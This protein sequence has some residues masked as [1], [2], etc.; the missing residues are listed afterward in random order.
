KKTEMFCDYMS[1]INRE[2][3]EQEVY[4]KHRHEVNAIIRAKL[5]LRFRRLVL[6]ECG[7]IRFNGHYNHPSTDMIRQQEDIFMADGE[8]VSKTATNCLLT[9]LLRERYLAARLQLAVYM[10][11]MRGVR[12]MLTLKLF[13]ARD[14]GYYRWSAERVERNVLWDSVDQFNKCQ[15]NKAKGTY[16]VPKHVI[17]M[18]H[19]QLGTLYKAQETS[20]TTKYG[21]PPQTKEEKDKCLMSIDKAQRGSLERVSDILKD[22]SMIIA[23]IPEKLKEPNQ[24]RT[25]DVQVLILRVETTSH[26]ERYLKREEPTIAE[27]FGESQEVAQPEGEGTA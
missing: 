3:N 27:R 9:I 14:S 20:W 6:K 22:F 21:Q 1:A 25:A 8:T 24:N 26:S 16:S 18:A 7:E 5:L 19:S 13:P 12:N 15:V 17:E 4:T 23:A 2:L 11:G 10:A